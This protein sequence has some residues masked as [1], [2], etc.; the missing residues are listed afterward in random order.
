MEKGTLK[1]HLYGS[2]L[3]SLSWKERLEICIGAARGLH[4]LHTGYAKAV[5]HCDMKFA[6]I[7]LDENLMVKVTDFGLSKTG[8]EIDQTHVSTTVKSS[9]G[10]LDLEY[11]RRQQL[12]EKLDVYS[13][14]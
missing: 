13:F 9:F 7:L 11:L 1:G 5:I 10:Y 3:P 14:G 12:T 8:P 6:N 2:G 4:Y